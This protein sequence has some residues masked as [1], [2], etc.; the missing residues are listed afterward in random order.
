MEKIYQAQ[1][2]NA[3]TN[4]LLTK[5]SSFSQEGLEEEMGKTKFTKFADKA[6]DEAPDFLQPEKELSEEDE[7]VIDEELENEANWLVDEERI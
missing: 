3:E 7:R 4:E 5:V 2:L 6:F 1:I